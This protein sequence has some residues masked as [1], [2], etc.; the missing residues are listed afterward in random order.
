[1]QLLQLPRRTR[2]NS[3]LIIPIMK[4]YHPRPLLKQEGNFKL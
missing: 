1:M 3:V 4:H 2:K